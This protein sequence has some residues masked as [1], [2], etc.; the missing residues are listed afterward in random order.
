MLSRTVL[1]VAIL[2]ALA[3]PVGASAQQASS[4]AGVQKP[5]AAN[6]LF[7]FGEAIQA[8]SDLRKAAE[9]AERF[10]TLLDGVAATIAES[11]AAM[12]REFDPFGYKSAFR[13]I[14]QQ[15]EIIQEQHETIRELLEK[16]NARLQAENE[17]L[18][19]HS[20]RQRSGRRRKKSKTSAGRGATLDS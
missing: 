11:M 17:L 12:S 4:P 6:D 16:E 1:L 19:R 18:R 5:S 20:K 2:L 3:V 9:A 14:E 13:T 15:N 8:A 7:K 10:G